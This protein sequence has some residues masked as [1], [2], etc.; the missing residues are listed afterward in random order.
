MSFL[1]PTIICHYR[2][3]TLLNQIH[4]LPGLT[5]RPFQGFTAIQS[6][7]CTGATLPGDWDLLSMVLY[8]VSSSEL[9]AIANLRKRSCSTSQTFIAC[10]ID[11]SDS[12]G[13][14][15]KAL[16]SDLT[17]GQSRA[18]GCNLTSLSSAGQ[19]SIVSWS[20][21]VTRP[22]KYTDI[23]FFGH[24][25][26]LFFFY[27]LNNRIFGVKFALAALCRCIY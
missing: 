21:V 25:G 6:V 9:L 10:H 15:I 4:T 18:Y 24:S 14:K 13:S 27:C 2:E 5:S 23:G 3:D 7:E 20:L 1:F 8:R 26:L 16:I 19:S 11:E 22:S 17:E 12:R